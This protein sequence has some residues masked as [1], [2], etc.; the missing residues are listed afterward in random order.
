[1]EHSIVVDTLIDTTP[2]ALATR[3]LNYYR[4]TVTDGVDNM[5]IIHFV[6]VVDDYP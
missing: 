2:I 5:T 6:H 1:M 4:Y 3:H